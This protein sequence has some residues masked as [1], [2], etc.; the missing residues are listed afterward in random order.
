MGAIGRVMRRPSKIIA[1]AL[2]IGGILKLVFNPLANGDGI[3]QRLKTA[4]DA[5]QNN[6]LAADSQ[7]NNILSITGDVI[8]ANLPAALPLFA[9]SI[10]VSVLGRWFKV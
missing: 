2:V 6:P 3:A 4:M 10:I 5:S 1:G 7:G 9:G 8:V